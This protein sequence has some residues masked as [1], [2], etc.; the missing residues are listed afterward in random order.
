MDSAKIRENFP[1][2]QDE[3]TSKY[4]E[5]NAL[6]D[7]LEELRF[8]ENTVDVPVGME[9]ECVRSPAAYSIIENV[10]GTL[11]ANDPQIRIPPAAVTAK[12]QQ[13]S[14]DLEKW[15]YGALMQLRMQQNED[16]FERFMECLVAYGHGCMKMMY[17]PQKWKGF[18]KQDKKAKETEEA[19]NERSETWKQGRPLPVAWTWCDPRTVYP[20]WSDLGLEAV[21][22]LD[23]R[24]P[25]ALAPYRF[26]LK[27]E[28]DIL[29]LERTHVKDSGEIE[30]AQLWTRETLTYA[31]DGVVVH[32]EKHKYPNVPY[33]YAM[34]Q[35][36]ASKDPAYMGLSVIYAIRHLLP[37][38]DR[39]LSQ[40]ASAIRLYGWPTVV[41]E[42]PPFSAPGE[43]LEGGDAGVRQLAFKPGE[44]ISL[45]P[46]EKV[47]FLQWQGEAPDIARQIAMVSEMIE[48]AG[49][50][51][52]SMG[53]GADQSGYAINQLI[54]A[55]RMK[56]KPLIRH[57]EDALRQ[58]IQ[59]LWDIVEYRVGQKVPVYLR[60]GKTTGWM[61]IG[62]DD[63]KGYRH[64]EVNLNPL[65]PTDT[66]ARSSQAINEYNSGLR[67]RRSAREMIGIEQPEEEEQ[68][69]L[70]EMF[71]DRQ[72]IQD[73]MS[74]AMIRKFG[75]VLEQQQQMPMGE[76]VQRGMGLPPAYQQAITDS[77]QGQPTGQPAPE[78]A[79]QQQGPQ[80]I[81]PQQVLMALQQ[82][83]IDLNMIAQMVAQGQLDLNALGQLD[84]NLATQI[85]QLLQQMQGGQGQGT[86]P[87]GGGAP[88][89]PGPMG[90]NLPPTAGPNM[91]GMQSTAVMGQPYTQ[92]AP[93]TPNR[94]SSGPKSPGRSPNSAAGAHVGRT[95]RP[96][97]IS[98][99]MPYGSRPH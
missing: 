75:F 4:Q 89:G 96:S 84:P 69:R 61:T 86:P 36:V 14:S 63:L 33:I 37:Y 41:Y 57:G 39:L 55:A 28:V 51:G 93:G 46:G 38:Y 78:G 70:I 83:Q 59:T 6:I 66:Y 10:L 2:I 53:V 65:L 60:E 13:S 95:V 52:T 85:V 22:E 47:G 99:R 94:S 54:G 49:I 43:N 48:R 21:L 3:L 15:T 68:Q 8:M 80:Q 58:V 30:F 32:H 71:L 77:M 76:L 90:A 40:N 67:A 20:V 29:E 87:I 18:P 9:A 72:E 34:G 5:R 1:A 24:D 81:D 19:Y 16:V 97:G 23:Y 45:Q 92:A 82:G 79:M 91:A 12:A 50:P 74:Q 27:D 64:V 62:P 44:P 31:I 11:V 88:S 26:N 56:L 7:E 42:E 17:A 73:A 25:I 35:A 98:Q